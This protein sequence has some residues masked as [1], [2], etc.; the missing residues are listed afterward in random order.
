VFHGKVVDDLME[1]A[2]IVPLKVLKGHEVKSGLGVLDIEWH[3]K[4]PVL[5]SAGADG[6]CRMWV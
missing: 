2:T 4:D 1:N 5:V 6:T 3:P